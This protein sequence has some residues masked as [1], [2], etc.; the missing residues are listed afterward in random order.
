[1]ENRTRFAIVY[2]SKKYNAYLLFSANQG[3]YHYDTAEA[4]IQAR[5]AFAEDAK[6]K[7]GIDELKVIPVECYHHGD[8]VK[9]VFDNHYVNKNEV[10][11]HS[12]KT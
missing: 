5:D 9:A 4:A 1:M 11:T 2:F 3:R 12:T 10:K 8:A 7:L 6:A